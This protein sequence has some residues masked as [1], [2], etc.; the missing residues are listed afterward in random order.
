[1]KNQRASG[2]VGAHLDAPTGAKVAQISNLLYRRFPNRLPHALSNAQEYSKSSAGWEACDTAGWETCATRPLLVVVARCAR[3]V[4]AQ[5]FYLDTVRQPDYAFG[6]SRIP[7]RQARTLCSYQEIK[8][9][10]A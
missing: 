7:L 8:P 2:Y 10:S 1:M 5:A 3:Y 6:R 9:R 4:G